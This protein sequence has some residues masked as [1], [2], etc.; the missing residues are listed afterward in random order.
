MNSDK[1]IIKNLLVQGIIGV[2]DWERDKAQDILINIELFADLS[3]AGRSDSLEQSINYRT[4]TESVISHVKKSQPLTVEAL[5][6][7]IASLC[8]E[9]GNALKVRVRVE[10]P[11]ALPAA[12]SAGVEIERNRED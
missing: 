1:V 2:E 4:L 12:E 3:E 10:K 6:T 11:Q 8:L 5:A 7:T 9:E